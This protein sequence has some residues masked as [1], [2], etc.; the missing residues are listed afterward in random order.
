MCD[1]LGGLSIGNYRGFTCPILQRKNALPTQTW[2]CSK[3][4][5]VS[6]GRSQGMRPSGQ[7]CSSHMCISITI[8]FLPRC[9]YLRP[10]AERSSSGVFA[11]VSYGGEGGTGNHKDTFP[12]LTQYLVPS[13]F[14]PFPESPWKCQRLWANSEPTPTSAPPL[15][16]CA[17]PWGKI[18]HWGSSCLLLFMLLILSQ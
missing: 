14:Y 13:H 16:W 18:E 9:L 8:T 6:E 1:F 5:A 7:S 2:C 12:Q 15:D 10:W 17:V 4:T 3:C 11:E